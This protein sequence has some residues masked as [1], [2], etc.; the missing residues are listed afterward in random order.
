[1]PKMS[2]TIL[3]KMSSSATLWQIKRTVK[4]H[5]LRLV[6]KTSVGLH[7]QLTAQWVTSLLTHRFPHTPSGRPKTSLAS[8]TPTPHLQPVMVMIHQSQITGKVIPS[9]LHGRPP[10]WRVLS[11]CTPLTSQN[12]LKILLA[13]TGQMSQEKLSTPTTISSKEALDATKIV[14]S[15]A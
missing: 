6:M 2:L 8:L 9:S 14:P 5:R 4:L 1:M 7:G 10:I 12:G 15:D 11:L 3:N 13:T